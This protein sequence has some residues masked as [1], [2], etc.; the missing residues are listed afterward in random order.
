ME[1]PLMDKIWVVILM[2]YVVLLHFIINKLNNIMDE[3][4]AIIKE[5]FK[6]IG[7]YSN[8]L[9]KNRKDK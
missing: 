5:A 9:F 1:T 8:E 4:K 6:V 2:L 7:G 3:H